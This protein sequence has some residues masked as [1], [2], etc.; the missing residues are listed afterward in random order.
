MGRSRKR[1]FTQVFGASSKSLGRKI[2]LG[3]ALVVV[4]FAVSTVATIWQISEIRERNNHIT[5]HLE[6][7]VTASLTMLNGVNES[8]AA[9]RGWMLLNDVQFK[10]QRERVWKQQILPSL[11]TLNQLAR[12]SGSNEDHERLRQISEWTDSFARYQQQ[13]E[14]LAHTAENASAVEILGTN[15][16]PTAAKIVTS[17]EAV[18]KRERALKEQDIHDNHTRFSR[19]QMTMWSALTIGLGGCI[20]AGLYVIRS[21][22]QP[23]AKAVEMAD[24]IAN[25]KLDF[26]TEISGTSEAERLGNSLTRMAENLTTQIQQTEQSEE[27]LKLILD[28]AASGLVMI[29]HTGTIK[30]V[31]AQ[32]EKDFG[33]SRD[34]LIGQKVELLVPER[35]R[36]K[37]PDHRNGFVANPTTRAMGAGRDLFG[38]RKD[39]TEMPVELGLNPIQIGDDMFVLGSVVDISERKAAE[40]KLQQIQTELQKQNER[41]RWLAVGQQTISEAVRG[42]QMLE[43]LSS[44]AISELA[45][46]LNCQ[47]G[48]FYTMMTT[49]RNADSDQHDSNDHGQKNGSASVL[50]LTG[51]FAHVIRKHMMTEFAIGEG[52]VGQAAVERTRIVLTEVPNDYIRVASGL[53]DTPPN[54]LL[55]QPLVLDNQVLGV[56]ELGSLEP[57]T[58]LQLELLDRV[59]ESLA[60]AIN[61]ASNREQLQKLL[62]QTQIQSSKLQSQ[63]TELRKTNDELTER[64]RLLEE[65]EIEL[66]NQSEELQAANEELEEKS[67][68]MQAQQEELR[69]ANEELTARSHDLVQQKDELQRAKSEVEQKAREV[70]LASKYKSEFLANMSHELRTPLN[71]LLI[72]SQKLAENADGNLTEH[73]IESA[74][75]INVGGKDLL[76]LINDIL[77]L[78][79]VEAGKMNVNFEPVS[80][81]SMVSN[82][83]TQFAALAEEK[84][85]DFE[86]T[87]DEQTP[88]DITTD[89]QRVEQILKNLLSN[90]IKFTAQGSVRLDVG[91][92]LANLASFANE[93]ASNMSATESTAPHSALPTGE[94]AKVTGQESV[95]CVTFTV[96]DTGIGIPAEKQEAIFEAFQQV[97]GSTCRKYGGTGLGLTISRELSKLL[98]GR[99][100]FESI[101]GTGSSFTFALPVEPIS[102]P[103]DTSNE[104]PRIASETNAN[105]TA[106]L[107]TNSFRPSQL[108]SADRTKPSLLNASKRNDRQEAPAFVQD[109]RRTT[110]PGDH[111]IL[112]IEDDATLA[113]IM[114]DVCRKRGFKCLV[115]GDGTSAM[116]LVSEFCPKAIVLD[117]GLPDIDGVELLDHLKYNLATRHIPVHI[118]SGADA[119]AETLRRG[120]IGYLRKPASEADISQ[121]LE[122]IEGFLGKDLKRVMLVEDDENNRNAITQL[123]GRKGIE[124]VGVGTGKE[125]I[126]Q[127]ALRTFDCVVLDLGLPDMSGQELLKQIGNGKADRPPSII[128]TGKEL[129][130]DEHRALR[131][132]T[133]TIVVKGADSPER[134]LDEVTLFLHSVERDLSTEQRS[135]MRMLHDPKKMLSGRKVLLVDDDM[136]NLFALSSVL[137][138]AEL[139]VIKAENG[140]EALERLKADAEIEVVV[141]DVM[142]PVMDGIEATQRIRAEQRW[143]DLP[144]LALTAKA[145]PEDR[146]KCIDAGATDYLSKPVDVE[147]LLTLLKIWM[148]NH[149][150]R[151][152]NVLEC[153]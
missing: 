42:D 110:R 148:F 53:G 59:S 28:G 62:A 93:G 127:L 9:L 57:L 8:L 100:E 69:Q 74:R 34:E 128:Y 27:R 88:S 137:Q 40:A 116:Q 118:V 65:S 36:A 43:S 20:V 23:F 18:V 96:T 26:R 113:G 84:G 138:Q 70:E 144:I 135:V 80:V 105:A 61:A 142:M 16:A 151:G 117:L 112:V 124:I 103:P 107:P 46:Y 5:Q 149:N 63:Q 82:I 141:M 126:E 39:G 101:V 25:R 72:L 132:Y 85:L 73:Q 38:R 51:S 52:M 4:I 56:L 125:A 68:E 33:Y 97:D 131:E 49:N 121:L 81:Q 3:F 89:P 123:I 108:L 11:E 109:D 153:V 140:Q 111:S 67:L 32:L 136:R 37:H 44:R 133:D 1:I 87:I 95:A 21:T 102:V 152:E 55:I 58:S 7:S 79:K 14:D 45:K 64:T 106:S 115:A 12:K 10:L 146:Q 31:N 83:R 130:G 129:T 13:V 29:D 50:K 78:S 71:S 35:F 6:P 99:I 2:G 104:S 120:A 134:L 48:V 22:T 98:G 122:R 94:G 114:R 76:N 91:Q 150:E 90:A 15:A 143:K 19:L 41:D 145:M 24:A 139:V 86:I 54:N 66:K 47:V 75:I 77:D 30:L 119:E 17:L 92:S 60:I 147:R